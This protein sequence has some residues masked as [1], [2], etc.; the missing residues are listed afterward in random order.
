MRLL[1]WRTKLVAAEEAPARAAIRVTFASVTLGLSL[2]CAS[3]PPEEPLDLP[4]H[5]GMIPVVVTL[6][7]QM[8]TEVGEQPGGEA[9][10]EAEPFTI[11]LPVPELQE[12]I[13]AKLEENCF[14]RVSVL[15][16]KEEGVWK[17]WE[18]FEPP[19]EDVSEWDPFTEDAYWVAAA[20]RARTDVLMDCRVRYSGIV[21]H[22]TTGAFSY[23]LLLF[24]FG[25]PFCYWVDD[26]DYR[27]PVELMA[28]FYDTSAA[29]IATR[30]AADARYES[31]IQKSEVAFEGEDYDFVDRNGSH[32]GMYGLSLI[33]PS[34]F[35]R[36]ETDP[37]REQLIEDIIADMS[38]KLVTEVRLAKDVLLEA[39]RQVSFSCDI[40]GGEDRAPFSVK[41]AEDGTVRVRGA[42]VVRLGRRVEGLEI[43]EIL[44]GGERVAGGNFEESI[45]VLG[46]AEP[47][48]M[49]RYP[50]DT[51]LS[52]ANLED[53]ERAAL[54]AATELQIRITE[55]SMNNNWRTYT[56]P[57]EPVAVPRP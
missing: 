31:E 5:V 47:D 26:H 34:G 22:E 13:R 10:Q 57:I 42:F 35:L 54:E 51:T 7:G 40:D 39:P 23:N 50:L 36:K 52:P 24:V 12:A 15:P 1:D 41:R 38:D 3:A 19:S 43:Y 18:D 28:I 55:S 48:R 53:P 37:V 45:E 2:G 44:A 33:C 21:V 9:E 27:S 25:G 30:A 8:S 29:V 46:L 16:A 14:T 49:L 11:T 32:V 56:F 6:S 17:E 4:F 20:E